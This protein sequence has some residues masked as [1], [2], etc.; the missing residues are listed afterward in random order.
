MG[1]NKIVLLN[2]V[3]I[4]QAVFIMYVTIGIESSNGCLFW[5]WKVSWSTQK[6][7]SL[8]SLEELLVLSSRASI[9]KLIFPHQNVRILS[10]ELH[11]CSDMA[12][13]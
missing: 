6:E 5:I 3:F 8:S 10:T 12:S 4:P 11:I 7:C 9:R 1:L 2:S 13:C